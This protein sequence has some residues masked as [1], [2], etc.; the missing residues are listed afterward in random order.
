MTGGSVSVIG[1]TGGGWGGSVSISSGSGDLS[2][3]IDIKTGSPHWESGDINLHTHHGQIVGNINISTGHSNTGGG[4]IN[5][6][7]GAANGG[8]SITLSTSGSESAGSSINLIAGGSITIKTRD[9]DKP[10]G[11]RIETGS[12]YL[13]NNNIELTVGTGGGGIILNPR[14]SLVQVIGSGTYTGTWTQASDERYKSNIKPLLGILNKVKMLQPVEYEW[15]KEEY[16][17]NN[18]PDGNQ[19]GIIAQEVEKLFTE[20]F[21][22]NKNG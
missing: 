14:A 9:I 6:S 17:E 15:N 11:I 5:L 1:G 13:G 19:I 18:F 21:A 8:N 16:P 7:T 2:G 20:I 22:K 3:N 10:R 4:S 12:S